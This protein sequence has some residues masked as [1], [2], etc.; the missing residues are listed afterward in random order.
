MFKGYDVIVVAYYI[1][2]LQ[3]F[4]GYDYKHD[5]YVIDYLANIVGDK[6]VWGFDSKT[7]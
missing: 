5:L 1:L 6:H 7:V 2:C 3:F 4:E